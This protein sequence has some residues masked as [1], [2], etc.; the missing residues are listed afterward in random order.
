V[1]EETYF[2]HQTRGL[3]A[4]AAVGTRPG[5][6]SSLGRRPWWG[7]GDKYGSRVKDRLGIHKDLER[8]KRERKKER[9]GVRVESLC[10]RQALAVRDDVGGAVQ[11]QT[12][13]QQEVRDC[14]ISRSPKFNINIV[15][16]SIQLAPILNPPNENPWELSSWF[17]VSSSAVPRGRSTGSGSRNRNGIQT[18]N[19][20]LAKHQ[21]QSRSPFDL[22]Q[23]INHFKF[24][25]LSSSC[26]RA[27]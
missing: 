14:M 11:T 1:G 20:G 17:H 18:T 16:K 8:K 24:L 13:A 5:R 21:A 12:Q 6:G 19:R 3:G 22:G 2:R 23:C 25:R 15:D 27:A 4:I 9:V 7:G 10:L 26:L